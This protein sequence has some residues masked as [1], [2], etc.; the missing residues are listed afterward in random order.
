M[1]GFFVLFGILAMIF[2]WETMSLQRR[3][4]RLHYTLGSSGAY[5]PI[6]PTWGGFMGGGGGSF[7][8]GGGGGGGGFSGGGGSFGGGGA[9]GE[10]EPS[11]G[12]R[13]GLIAFSARAISPPSS[14][15]SRAPER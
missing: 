11:P 14:P 13:A 15:R 9:S 5:V 2:A 8:G 3:Q 7:G 1:V 4:R 12:I 10:W 6:G